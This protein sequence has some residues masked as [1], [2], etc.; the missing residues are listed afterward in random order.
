MT[1]DRQWSEWMA[2]FQGGGRPLRA[3]DLA[4]RMRRSTVVMAAELGLTLTACLGVAGVLAYRLQA[5]PHPVVAAIVAIVIAFLAASIVAFFRVRHG[6]W[7][8]AGETPRALAALLRRREESRLR[9]A[10]FSMRSSIILGLAVTLWIPWKLWVDWE[11][12]AREPWRAVVGVGGVY[13]LLAV[14]LVATR[15]WRIRKEHS[16]MAAL[17]MERS[18]DESE[19]GGEP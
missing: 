2:D 7:R 19:T 4:R 6:A 3:P 12:Y 17:E 8:A 11:G 5:E 13:V 16:L 14:A 9:E 18:F 10:R 15:W 1:D